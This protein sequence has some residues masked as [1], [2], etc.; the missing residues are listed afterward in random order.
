MEIPPEMSENDLSNAQ[1]LES[2]TDKKQTE[3]KKGPSV[4]FSNE[5]HSD[6]T[7]DMCDW[8]KTELV[9]MM[10]FLEA[11]EFRVLSSANG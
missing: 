2:E 7:V 3:T 1:F 6:C 11:A 8:L 4:L 9:G 5:R 10:G